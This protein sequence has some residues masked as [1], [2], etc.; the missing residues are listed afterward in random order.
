VLLMLN[1]LKCMQIHEITDCFSVRVELLVWH[2]CVCWF[3][4][5]IITFGLNDISHRYLICWFI[6]TL[7]KTYLKGQAHRLEF[8]LVTGVR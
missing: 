5:I 6:L 1:L 3:V 8:L 7:P 2:V 4:W